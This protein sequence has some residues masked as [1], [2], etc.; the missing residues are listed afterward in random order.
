MIR[1]DFGD[2]RIRCGFT[3]RAGGVSPFPAESMNMSFSREPNAEN[4]LENYRRAALELGVD[5]DGL[6]GVKQVHGRD[7]LLVTGNNAGLNKNGTY[8]AMITETPGITLC[9]VHADCTPIFLFDPVHCAVAAIHSG[10]RSTALRISQAVVEAMGIHFGTRP[11]DLQAIIG[12]AISLAAFEVDED[13]YV[14]FGE[15]FPNFIGNPALCQKM[16]VKWHLSV[17]GFVYETLLESGVPAKQ[18][19]RD[20]TC[21]FQRED[22]FF[23][24]RRDRGTT[25]AMSGMIGIL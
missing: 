12:P 11:E 25:G 8:D 4:V 21:T 20:Q 18:I 17:P 16:G 14:A 7:V 23:S 22:L 13:V 15:A 10:W 24:H 5:F 2:S 1:Y 3:T 6:T 9:T 19:R